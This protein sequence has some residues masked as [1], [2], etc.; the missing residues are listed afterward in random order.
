MGIKAIMGAKLG[1]LSLRRTTSTNPFEHNSFRG[2]SFG[3]SVL[4]FA[5][6]FQ[7]I[8]PV[9]PKTSKI[10][11]ISGSVIGAVSSFKTRLT[12]PIIDFAHNV[13]EKVANGIQ[14]VK[15]A[16]NTIVEAGKSIPA[17]I[18][19]LFEHNKPIAENKDIP[20]ILSI[21][22]INNKA[23]IQDLKATWIAE[24]ELIAKGIEEAGKV[25]A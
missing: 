21:K 15:N 20:K 7:S 3:G 11:M 1:S 4:P 17:R 22:H 18:T 25:A 6:V 9:E 2:K 16:R 5:D 14:A 13:S 23:S 24:N 12:Q 8:K 10:K 19:G